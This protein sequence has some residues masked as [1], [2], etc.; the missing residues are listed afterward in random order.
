MIT[1]NSPKMDDHFV[2]PKIPVIH[3]PQF[4]DP[5]Q[6]K[7]PIQKPETSRHQQSNQKPEHD[8]RRFLPKAPKMCSTC[9]ISLLEYLIPLQE[10][11]TEVIQMTVKH[12][13]VNHMKPEE[14]KSH[15]NVLHLLNPDSGL[16]MSRRAQKGNLQLTPESSTDESEGEVHPNE[17]TYSSYSGSSYT[18]ADE[19]DYALDLP[20]ENQ[21][22]D[23]KLTSHDRHVKDSSSKVDRDQHFTEHRDKTRDETSQAS[24]SETRRIRVPKVEHQGHVLTSGKNF[25][26]DEHHPQHNSPQKDDGPHEVDTTRRSSGLRAQSPYRNTKQGG[27]SSVKDTLSKVDRDQNFTEH[28]GKTR[29]ETSQASNSEPMPRKSRSRTR[30]IRVHKGQNHGHVLTSGK[31]YDQ[32]EHHPQHH[33][34]QKADGPHKVDTTRSSSEPRTQSPHRNTK[35]GGDS[36]GHEHCHEKNVPRQEYHEPIVAH[37][38]HEVRHEEPSQSHQFSETKV[39]PEEF[40]EISVEALEESLVEYSQEEPYA[41]V[42]LVYNNLSAVNAIV[43]ANSVILTTQKRIVIFGKMY[44]IPFVVLL[45]GNID[46]LLKKAL[47]MVFDQ[48]ISERQDFRLSLLKDSSVGVQNMKLQLWRSLDRFKKCLFIESSCLVSGFYN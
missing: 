13:G 9:S 25:Y 36:S 5:N 19:G 38:D 43:L 20:E 11:L 3:V 17:K 7:L 30:R 14:L 42:T 10:Y 31:N 23:P 27:D 37:H 26:Q 18:S 8:P 39:L 45:E 15:P 40:P 6:P 16:V 35:Q 48:V 28:R 41:Y 44:R 32:D 21:S 33:S 24:N 47:A 4:Q 46:P 29:H 34:P 2:I 1:T 22:T 12:C